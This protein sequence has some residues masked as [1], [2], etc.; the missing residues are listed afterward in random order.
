MR[1]PAEPRSILVI[2]PSWVG[3]MVMAQ[4]LFRRLKQRAPA[5]RLTVAAP[6]ATLPLLAFMPEV[7]A[8]LALPFRHGETRLLGRW[9]LGR[10]WRSRA[11][12]WGLVLPGSFKAALPLRAAAVARRTGYV[13][14]LRWALLND[15]RRLDKARFPATLERF[16]AL[17][18][19][20]GA[21]VAPRIERPTLTVPPAAT[22][23]ALQRL[24]L[25]R[26]TSPLLLLCPGAEYGPAKRWPV[27][28][29]AATAERWLAAGGQAWLLGGPAD[30][31]LGTAIAAAAP[32]ALDLTGRTSLTEAVA[33]LTLADA[34]V[35]NDSG[36]MHV[37]AALDRPLIGL[38]GPT[39][40]AMTPPRSPRATT[41]ALDL[42]CRPCHART[43]P[44]T[45]HRC[46][47]DLAPARLWPHLAPLLERRAP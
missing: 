45:H 22:A 7:D 18:E 12:D 9:C 6:E 3:D 31:P 16:L 25:Q 24:G 23:T 32:A 1:P 2:A 39:D 29:F 40:V 41:L 11:F 19:E 36:L 47:E 46:L 20:A 44:L 15:C 27:R 34:V 5:A 38:Y 10:S 33:L 21:A 13:G 42:S 43:C 28:H 8:T 37:A 30:R 26:P 4:G 17:A 14:E 35:S